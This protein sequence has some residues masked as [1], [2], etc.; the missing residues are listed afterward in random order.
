MLKTYVISTIYVIVIYFLAFYKRIRDKAAKLYGEVNSKSVWN[1]LYKERM[2][3]W[4]DSKGTTNRIPPTT[5]DNVLTHKPSSELQNLIPAK[6]STKMTIKPIRMKVSSV[7]TKQNNKDDEIPKKRKK[8]RFENN[9]TLSASNSTTT[10]T[11]TANTNHTSMST[12]VQYPHIPSTAISQQPP[13]YY[14]SV[15]P[16]VSNGPELFSYPLAHLQPTIWPL[17]EQQPVLFQNQDN[18]ALMPN[19]WNQPFLDVNMINPG[20]YFPEQFPSHMIQ[21]QPWM[22]MVS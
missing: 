14:P 5:S 6:K 1:A 12:V 7:V 10:N 4:P 21:Q 19:Q 3:K 9:A 15:L 2:E 8:T 13:V 16:N 18:M 11:T 20:G 22:G 17:S